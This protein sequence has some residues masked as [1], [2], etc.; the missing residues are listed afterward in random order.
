MQCFIDNGFHGIQLASINRC[1]IYLQVITLSD[2]STG[3]G[4]RID[5]ST[6]TGV[7]NTNI[8]TEYLWPVQGKPGKTD[9]VEWR[10]AIATVF[11]VGLP[12][13]ILPTSYQL[14]EWD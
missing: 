8:R 10:R 11:F 3:D 2:I 13:L 6:Y 5:K 1:R 7:K 14:N 4:L 12:A 9:W